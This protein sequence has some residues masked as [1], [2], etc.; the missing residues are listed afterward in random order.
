MS[1]GFGRRSPAEEAAEAVAALERAVQSLRATVDTV[2][3]ARDANQVDVWEEQS[4]RLTAALDQAEQ[5]LE[6]ARTL[7]TDT[8]FETKRRL[9]AA[10]ALLDEQ[11]QAAKDVAHAPAGF[12]PLDGE[13]ELLA[14]FAAPLEGGAKVGFERKQ[15][16][17]QAAFD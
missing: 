9:D 12:T 7:A 6:R 11:K 5:A 10:V 17:L 16:A 14:V 15:I 13:P 4:G 3:N 2:R 1:T 8:S